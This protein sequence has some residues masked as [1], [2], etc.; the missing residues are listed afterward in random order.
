MLLRCTQD[1]F[2]LQSSGE[3]QSNYVK[4]SS[5]LIQRD[6]GLLDMVICKNGYSKEKNVVKLGK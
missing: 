1:G 6:I 5:I 4:R 3:N 2:W